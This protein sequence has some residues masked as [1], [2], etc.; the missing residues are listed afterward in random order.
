MRLPDL[1]FLNVKS[2]ERNRLRSFGEARLG[3]E[4]VT[5]RPVRA[6]VE[7]TTKCPFACPQCYRTVSVRRN[8]WMSADMTDQVLDELCRELFPH[9]FYLVV[10]G[11]GELFAT[12]AW[13]RFLGALDPFP[14]YKEIVTSG[15]MLGAQEVAALA[16]RR[17]FV[18]VSMDGASQRSYDLYRT[19]ASHAEVV[20]GI[21]RYLAAAGGDR[22]KIIFTVMA[23]NVTE[24]PEIV[25]FCGE[26]GIRNLDF[27]V[28]Q[29]TEPL[30]ADEAVSYENP[31]VR[32]VFQ[33]AIARAR[34]HR[35]NLVLPMG[36]RFL[37]PV[38]GSTRFAADAHPVRGALRRALRGNPDHAYV[39]ARRCAEPWHTV[40]VNV[41]GDMAPCSV[42]E[43]IGFLHRESFPS[44]WNGGAIRELRRELAAGRSPGRCATC[45]KNPAIV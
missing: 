8:Q 39:D 26:R 40:L 11:T 16:S 6:Y 44:V 15:M 43:P 21:D 19:G 38:P 35:I 18:S 25:T 42:R 29:I 32:A 4:T 1:S 37:D 30:V 9:L 34:R 22:L 28:L 20:A 27:G 17:V 41:F 2:F 10:C 14:C 31:D 7:F 36:G 33:E 23:G 3:A 45:S 12:E 24:V 13:P 5:A